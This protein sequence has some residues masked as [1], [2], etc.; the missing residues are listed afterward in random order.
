M[1]ANKHTP[2]PWNCAALPS[3]PLLSVHVYV[4]AKD[5]KEPKALPV[6][7]EN[8]RLIAAAPELL[9]AAQAA[10]NCIGE[11]PPTQARVEAWQ[12]LTAAIAKATGG[13]A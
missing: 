1:T 12:L 4:D 6:T 13:A 5:G 9:E 3:I 10:M 2:G 7:E 8:A 11:L